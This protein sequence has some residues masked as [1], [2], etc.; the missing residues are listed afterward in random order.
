L[1]PGVQVTSVIPALRRPRQEDHGFKA[2]MDSIKSSCLKKKFFFFKLR[3]EYL[4]PGFFVSV[5]GD[6][7]VVLGVF[8]QDCKLPEGRHKAWDLE[9]KAGAADI[10]TAAALELRGRTRVDVCLTTCVNSVSG[11]NEDV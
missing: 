11:G 7:A 5:L 2:S 1:K 4:K 8:S 6:I 3:I 9:F 10:A